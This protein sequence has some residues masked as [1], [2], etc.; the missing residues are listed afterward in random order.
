MLWRGGVTK[1]CNTEKEREQEQKTRWKA[2]D[3]DGKWE[4][5]ECGEKWEEEKSCVKPTVISD[6]SKLAQHKKNI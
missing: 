4:T 1:L 3:Q 5:E 2:R 6:L